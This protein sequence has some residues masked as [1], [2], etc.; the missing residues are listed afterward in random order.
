MIEVENLTKHYGPVRAV[1]DVSFRVEPG[2]ILGFLG[3]NGA[4][5]TTTMR[6]LAGF[7]PATRGEARVAG[8][9]VRKQSLSARAATGYMPENV[10]LYP[11]MRVRE[12]LRYRGA[13]KGLT[14]AEI[15]G[16][17]ASVMDRC[18]LEAHQRSMIRNLSKGFRQRV[19]LAASLVHD[20]E[21]LILDEPTVGLDP[22][23]VREVRALIREMGEQ[24]TVIL[25]SH[26]LPEV[27]MVC[28]LVA[29]IHSGRIAFSGTLAELQG[30][31]L[32]TATE[33]RLAIR[34]TGGAVK[35]ALERIPG[36]SRVLWEDHGAISSYSITGQAD[37]LAEEVGRAATGT[38]ATIRELS[39]NRRSLEDLFVQITAGEREEG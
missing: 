25:S 28:D 36:V 13:L 35:E 21:V 29:I 22:Y 5:K 14:R 1:E 27:E 20:P 39:S 24:R 26:I 33:V 23:Q 18:G 11:D 7:I 31:G 32:G 19:G 12:Y 37:E 6:I 15:N 3:Q 2:Q 17:V 38:G 16:A 10:P 30:R 34:G 8:F 9:D 4:G